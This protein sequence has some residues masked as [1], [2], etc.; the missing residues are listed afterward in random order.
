METK[1]NIV[2]VLKTGGDFTIEDVRLQG[3]HLKECNYFCLHDKIDI[4]FKF[5]NNSTILP[6]EYKNWKG[7]WSKM[8]IFSPS[9]EHLRPF[10]YVDLDTAFFSPIL[11]FD[12][13]QSQFI[14]LEDFYQPKKAA[15][16]LMWI[17]KNN[18]KID[19]I[20]IEWIKDPNKHISKF[21]GDQNFINSIVTPDKFWQ[22]LTNE[23]VSFK[24]NKKWKT[25][26]NGNESIVCFH[27]KPRLPE[28]AKTVEWVNNYVN[29]SLI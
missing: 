28:A 20:W 1:L 21:R 16:G 23:I 5:K 27:G 10:L 26:L 6:M 4:N 12:F 18:Q 11:N 7:W 14:M 8:N 25:V 15:S 9:L 2:S 13:D 17:P 19:K 22:E 29:S 24:P 3:F